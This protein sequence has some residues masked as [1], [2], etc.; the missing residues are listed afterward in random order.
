[1]SSRRKLLELKHVTFEVDAIAA[2]DTSELPL[3]LNAIQVAAESLR[4]LSSVFDAADVEDELDRR[5]LAFPWRLIDC[6]VRCDAFRY[7]MDHKL[8]ERSLKQH[9]VFI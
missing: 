1:M 2:F 7:L 4:R 6:D 8:K 5:V 9:V 3:R